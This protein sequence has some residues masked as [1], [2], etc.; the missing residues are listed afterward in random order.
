LLTRGSWIVEREA[1]ITYS[2]FVGLLKVLLPIAALGILST[3]FLLPDNRSAI[4]GIDKV[5]E[6]ILELAAS[7]GIGRPRF[8]GTT[9]GGASL[10]MWAK[11]IRPINEE[12]TITQATK[13]RARLEVDK[14][15]GAT[16]TAGSGIVNTKTEI[17]LLSD[18]FVANTFSGYHF[19][20]S[21]VTVVVATATA[22]TTGPVFVSG[23]FG[24]IEADRASLREIETEDGVNYVVDFNGSV[25]LIYAP[26][27]D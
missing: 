16:A 20:T 6:E 23:S 9:P 25:K 22:T 14:F 2:K 15:T 12:K 18:G 11:R 3:L 4:R 24:T 8:N 7:S 5:S 10:E 1:Q 13:I 21:G 27:S 19:K 17:M 26:S